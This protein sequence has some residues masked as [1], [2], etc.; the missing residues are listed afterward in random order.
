MRV[1]FLLALTAGAVLPLAHAPFDLFWAAPVSYAVLFHVWSGLKPAQALWSGFAFG[2]AGF[3]AGV[4]WVYV[5]IH[6]FGLAHPLLAGAI[7]LALVVF[8]GAYV[9][10]SGW[11]RGPLVCLPGAG[12]LVRRVSGGPGVDGVV[13]RMGIE[14]FRLARP[15]I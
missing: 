1:K 6:D 3:L 5:S 7:T 8:L 10:L 9:G 12:G 11:N 13:P 2:C 14:R 15:G 4:H